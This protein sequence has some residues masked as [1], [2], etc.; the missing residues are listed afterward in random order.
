MTTEG[1][2]NWASLRD[3][4]SSWLSNNQVVH[5]EIVY[6]QDTLNRF[7]RFCVQMYASVCIAIIRKAKE[8][9]NLRRRVGVWGKEWREEREEWNN[10]ILN[11]SLKIN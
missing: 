3:K 2:K 4:P 10:V 6:A 8:A 11:V 1:G 5:P 7:S 9:T